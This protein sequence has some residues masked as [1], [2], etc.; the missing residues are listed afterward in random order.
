MSSLTDLREVVD[1]VIGVDTHVHTHSAAAVDAGTG[2]VLGEIT[3]EATADGYARLVT[4]A[5]EHARLR[6]WAIEGTGGHGA[7]LARHLAELEE[8]VVEL[9]RPQRAHRRNGAKSD[10]LDAIR[11]A[12]EAMSRTRLGTPRHGGDRQALS[13]LLAARRS[14]VEAATN[15]QRQL[16]SLIIAAPEPIRGRFRGQKLPGML[17]TAAGLRIHSS[18]DAETT[19]TVTV[20]RCLARR[21]RDLAREAAEHEKAV[22]AIV[23]SWRPDLLAQPGVGPIVAATVLCAW[24]H[25]GRI[26]SEAA[27]AMLAG[28]APIPA[29]SGQVTTRHR[30]N[31]YGDRQLNRALHTIAL[32]RI[33]YDTA[34]RDYVARRTIEGKTPREIKRC[35]KRYIARDLYRLLEHQPSPA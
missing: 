5:D 20:L 4:F 17:T 1:V 3:V 32:S 10:P 34:T 25:P 21:A 24:S 22:L 23:R 9:D 30:L 28:V 31:R 11:A 18:W 35:L 12:R 7:G 14:A 8:V 2:G 6:A 16:F 27:F 19:A 13:V 29:T 33:H 15:A 26:H